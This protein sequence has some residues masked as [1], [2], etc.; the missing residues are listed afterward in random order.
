MLVLSRKINEQIRISDHI[1]LTVIRLQSGKVKLGIECPHKI[2]VRRN[3]LP[4]KEINAD[5]ISLR[6][7]CDDMDCIIR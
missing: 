4:L 3:E 5:T 1:V 6:E 2:K 7:D